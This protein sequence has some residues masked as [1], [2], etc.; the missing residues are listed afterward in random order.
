[1][2]LYSPVPDVNP[3]LLGRAPDGSPLL[4]LSSG[5]LPLMLCLQPARAHTYANY[6]HA[7]TEI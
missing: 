6:A 1:M 7:S 3:S 2:P 4:T 5:M